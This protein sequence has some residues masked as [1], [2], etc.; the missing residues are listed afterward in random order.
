MLRRILTALLVFLAVFLLPTL[1][2]G[3]GA[4][5]TEMT[6]FLVVALLAA[7]ATLRFSRRS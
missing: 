6:I 1:L 2:L 4:G 7:A 5:P 3:S